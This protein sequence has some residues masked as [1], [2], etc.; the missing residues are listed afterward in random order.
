M[1]NHKPKAFSDSLTTEDAEFSVRVA[2]PFR[3]RKEAVI[4]K[5]D[6]NGEINGDEYTIGAVI[7]MLEL[8]VANLLARR[9]G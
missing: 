9:G 7:H 4:V 6:C 3:Q 2:R 5:I 8:A 1:S